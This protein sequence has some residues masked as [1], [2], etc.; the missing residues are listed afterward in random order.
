MLT[1]SNPPWRKV[2][3]FANGE[4]RLNWTLEV[5]AT[6]EPSVMRAEIVPS[7]TV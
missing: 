1:P 4:K 3:N 2:V 5:A 7:L 6:S